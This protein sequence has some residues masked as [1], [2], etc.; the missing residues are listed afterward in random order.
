MARLR[1]RAHPRKTLVLNTSATTCSSCA[2][3]L[4][5]DYRSHRVV[6][7]LDGP[8]GLD[9]QVRRCHA[10]GCALS[11][12]P[13]RAEEEGRFALPQQEFGLDV[14]ALVGALR[15]QDHRSVPE[16]HAALRTRH[17]SIAERSVTNL[18][19]RYDE[20]VS[21]AVTDLARLRR[22]A[23]KHG[24]VVL[25]L[26]GLQPDVGHEVLWVVRDC[27]TGEILHARTM[28][29][30][31]QQD[32]AAMLR[33][34]RDA[35]KVPVVGVVSD[36]QLSIRRAVA[37]ALPGVPHQLCHFHYL[38]EAAR[39]VFEADRHAKKLLKKTVRGV[40]P[41]ERAVEGRNDADSVATRGY[42]VAVRSALTDDGRPP[43]A[44]SGLKL[45]ERLRS[46]DASLAEVSRKRGGFRASW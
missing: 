20:L 12:V 46:I 29:S 13:V 9:I 23:R 25:A 33:Q 36:G 34:V 5:A 32:L 22:I 16:I 41:I 28:L 44:A 15:H 14:I 21:L 18:L 10:E 45:R 2:G 30:A 38:R 8:T 42:C 26:D 7:T 27:L 17:V 4:R 1:R 39:P 31:R 40:R 6:V 35:V 11:G 3:P 43:L 19:D 37:L 24:R